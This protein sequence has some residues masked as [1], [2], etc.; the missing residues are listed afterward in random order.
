MTEHA[1][2]KL[3]GRDIPLIGVPADATRDRCA[4]CGQTFHLSLLVLHQDKFICHKCV[5]NFPVDC[6]MIVSPR[7]VDVEQISRV[8]QAADANGPETKNKLT[9]SEH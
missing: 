9:R 4:A 3:D 5:D 6:C 1:T 2:V 7:R 8:A